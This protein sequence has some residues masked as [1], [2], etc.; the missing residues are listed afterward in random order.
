MGYH[1][2]YYYWEVVLMLRNSITILAV[3]IGSKYS[4]D[5]QCL[6]GIMMCFG[7]FFITAKLD[8]Q[9]GGFGSRLNIIGLS[10]YITRMY[11][12]LLYIYKN[13]IVF[14]HESYVFI[15]LLFAFT[16]MVPAYIYILRLGYNIRM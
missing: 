13:K 9:A 5:V 10:T 11:V 16:V 3:D 2:N 7:I 1:P 6:W 15:H 8:P 14:M 4:A 12:G